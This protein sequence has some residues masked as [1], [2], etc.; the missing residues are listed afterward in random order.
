MSRETWVEPFASLRQIHL[1]FHTPGFV[2]VGDRFEAGEFCDTLQAAEVNAVA[3]FALC[4]HGYSYFS[5][6]TGVRHPG[7]DF[8]LFGAICEEAARRGISVIAYFSMNVNEVLAAAR[9]EYCALSAEGRTVDRQVMQDGAVFYW[10]WL[11]PN[12]GGWIDTFFLPH[13]REV[14]NRYPVDGLFVDM[15]VYLPGSCFCA[16]CRARMADAGIDPADA[17]AHDGFNCASNQGVARRIRSLLDETR[18]G[19]RLQIGSFNAYGEARRARDAISDFYVESLA[20]QTGWQYFPMAA[21]YVRNFDLPVIGYTGR[22]LRNWGDF[23]SVVSAHQMKL[24][25]GMHLLAGTASGIGDHLHCNGRLNKAVYERIGETFR[26]VK[27]RQPYCVGMLPAREIALIVSPGV[28]GAACTLDRNPVAREM[29]DACQGAAKLMPELHFQYDLLDPDRSLEGYAAVVVTDDRFD[30]PFARKCREFAEGGG[31]VIVGAHALWPRDPEARGA[32]AEITGIR[33]F[34]FSD[35]EGEFIEL[36]DPMLVS[37]DI[38]AMPHRVH[39]RAVDAVWTDDLAAPAVTWRSPNARTETQFYGHYHGP[40]VTAAGP[41]IGLR[42]VGAG[43]FVLIRPQLFA[44]YLNTGYCVHRAIVRNL[45]NALLPVQRRVLRSNAPSLVEFAFGAKD[46]RL[47]LQAQ[48]FV[49]DRR[50]RFSF[51]SANEPVVFHDVHVELF[52]VRDVTRVRNPVTGDDLDFA[53][54]GH[55]TRIEL[56]PFHE[57]LVALVEQDTKRETPA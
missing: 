46:G 31:W 26:F 34:S 22:F 36:T 11:C 4:H 48:P 32:W 53:P 43:G 27:A 25:T 54:T 41:A 2:R 30:A 17:Q 18:P 57:H 44:S 14:L 29:I 38:P 15:A 45:L 33:S 6:Q 52:N 20:Y 47:V 56:P 3:V 12:R 8:D 1:D 9:P 21:R 7:L 50:D 51:E 10:T 49:A 28:Q 37:P 42:R 19:M 16:D 40:P 35:H 39:E 13:V 5:T 55:G 23:G 24:Q